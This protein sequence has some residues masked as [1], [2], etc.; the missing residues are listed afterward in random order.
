M[1]P[2]VEFE[3]VVVLE[4]VPRA[5]LERVG[6]FEVVGGVVGAVG[7]ELWGLD[8]AGDGFVGRG[9]GE[10]R[11]RGWLLCGGRHLGRL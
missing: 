3:D 1:V 2:G 8:S 11:E 7:G 6:S 4:E 10:S 9:Y 5:E